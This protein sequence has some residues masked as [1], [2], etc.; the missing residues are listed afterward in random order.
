MVEIAMRLASVVSLAALCLFAA[1]P[2]AGAFQIQSVPA[3]SGDAVKLTD[4][5]AATANL[6]PHYFTGDSAANNGSS[7]H[8]GSTTLSFGAT[9]GSNAS[10]MSPAL[11]ERLM[12]GY[13]GSNG[14]GLPNR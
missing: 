4:P 13:V 9:N 14:G 11:Q 10:T 1:V 12:G 2:L 8:I 6:T 3:N 7:L 5:D